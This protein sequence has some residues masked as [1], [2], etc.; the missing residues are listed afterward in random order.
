MAAARGTSGI[1]WQP[2]EC[3]TGTSEDDYVAATA[4]NNLCQRLDTLCQGFARLHVHLPVPCSMCDAC[5][6][7]T[8]S[9]PSCQTPQDS[10]EV[11]ISNY[12]LL[13]PY[14]YIL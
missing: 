1:Q 7:L 12:K 4:L 9:D 2:G 3:V 8:C 5:F 14:L 13:F 6:G 11:L 10:N